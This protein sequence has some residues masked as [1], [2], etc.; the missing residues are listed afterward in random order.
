MIKY[1]TLYSETNLKDNPSDYFR[2]TKGSDGNFYIFYG[3]LCTTHSY[4]FISKVKLVLK[5]IFMDE[6]LLRLKN[7]NISFSHYSKEFYAKKE[8]F[9]VS[10]INLDTRFV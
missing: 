5:N 9:S 8:N 3:S 10:V 4:S 2:L 1:E 6:F 7:K